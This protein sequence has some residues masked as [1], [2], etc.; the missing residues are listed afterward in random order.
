MRRILAALALVVAGMAAGSVYAAVSSDGT[1][2]GTG[3]TSSLSNISLVATSD[4]PTTPLI[5]GSSGDTVFEVSNPN[6]V[7]LTIV[8]VTG[9]GTITVSGAAGCTTS[10][11]GVSFTDQTGLSIS[12]PADAS[13]YE[14]DLPSSVSMAATSASACQGATFSIPV[15]VTAHQG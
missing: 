13:G 14:V 1:G 6:A 3:S 7:A 10:N 12:V 5:P 4:T 8:S 15:V 9:S 2:T 11:D